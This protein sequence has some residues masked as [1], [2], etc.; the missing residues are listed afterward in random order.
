VS[1]VGCTPKPAAKPSKQGPPINL[2]CLSFKTTSIVK[3]DGA[4]LIRTPTYSYLDLR[5][6]YEFDLGAMRDAAKLCDGPNGCGIATDK[7]TLDAL[8]G[9]LAQMTVEQLTIAG[10]QAVG[11]RGGPRTVLG[12]DLKPEELLGQFSAGPP[13][14]CT[15]CVWCLPGQCEIPPPIPTRVCD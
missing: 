8:V 14:I 15:S 7:P 4:T 2:P 13:G 5:D 6:G 9:E 3:V 10:V 12:V 1:L 11:Y